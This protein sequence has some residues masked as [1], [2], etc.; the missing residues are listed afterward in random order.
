MS[1]GGGGAPVGIFVGAGV[2]ACALI[3]G[4]VALAIYCYMKARKEKANTNMTKSTDVFSTGILTYLFHRLIIL[5]FIVLF[6]VKPVNKGH[7]WD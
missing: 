3:V 7:P 4:V 6:T 1:D 5:I 2:G